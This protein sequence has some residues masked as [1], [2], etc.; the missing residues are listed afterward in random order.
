VVRKRENAVRDMHAIAVRVPE[1]VHAVLD[2]ARAAYG[3]RSMQ[4]LVAPVIEEFARSLM[5][6]P[7]IAAMLRGRAELQAE[8]AGDLA[9]LRSRKATGSARERG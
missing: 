6:K 3:Q 9:T 2:V 1:E 8:A 5:D 4:E 7:Q